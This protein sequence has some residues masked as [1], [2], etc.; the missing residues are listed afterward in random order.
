MCHS[1]LDSAG[2]EVGSSPSVPLPSAGVPSLPRGHLLSCL[3]G[4]LASCDT[5]FLLLIPLNK[6]VCELAGF[7]GVKAW[8]SAFLEALLCIFPLCG[9]LWTWDGAPPG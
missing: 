3:S 5:L 8:K 4:P 6:R 7:F 1:W 2:G 9:P